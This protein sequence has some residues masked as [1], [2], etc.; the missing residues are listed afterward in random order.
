MSRILLITDGPAALPYTLPLLTSWRRDRHVIRLAATAAALLFQPQITWSAF[1]GS[2]ASAF[3]SLDDEGLSWPEI[4]VVAPASGRLLEVLG[5][6]WRE[7]LAALKIPVI[8]IPALLASDN[9]DEAMKQFR[10]ML[11]DNC[12]ILPPLEDK[13][14]LGALGSILAASTERCLLEVQIALTKP[15]L[16]GHHILLTAGPTIED[17]DPVRYIS[18]RSTGRMGL[19]IALAAIKRGAK[20]TLIHGPIN[21]SLP[22]LPE[23]LQAIP[24]RG[25]RE[26]YEV[27]LREI[28]NCDMAVLCAAVADYTPGFCAAQKIKKQAN[29][30]LHLDLERTPDILV[31]LG[32]LPQKPFLIGFAAESNDVEANAALKLQTKNCDMVCANNIT[33]PGCGFAVATNRVTIF[34]RDGSTEQLPL[35]SKDETANRILDKAIGQIQAATLAK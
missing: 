15:S 35:L 2:P 3:E 23:R 31:T 13:T 7:R 29:E 9:Q 1:S 18:N 10:Q 21:L 22:V 28:P 27:T 17:I 30:G 19:A 16:A 20:V 26:M 8:I 6:D 14:E 24:V 12:R 11:P 4:I 33:E 25:A 34:S 32:H 5:G